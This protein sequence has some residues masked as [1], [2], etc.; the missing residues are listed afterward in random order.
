MRHVRIQ[1]A[2]L[3]AGFVALS[4][5][6][7]AAA[8]PVSEREKFE[9]EQTFRDRQQA[10]AEG[11]QALR[12]MDLALRRENERQSRWTNPLVLAII[13][14]AI[15]ALGNALVALLNGIQQRRLEC[16]RAEA[17]RT[18]ER[19]KAENLLKLERDK[20]KAQIQLDERKAESDRILE[21]I[22][23]GE[24][25]TAA[26]NLQFLLS[27]GLV[28][29]TGLGERLTAFLATRQP[30]TG[31]ALPAADGR[32]RFEGDAASAPE[33]AEMDASLRRFGDYLDRVGFSRPEREARIRF[34]NVKN[35]YYDVAANCV[36]VGPK[37]RSDHFVAY[38]EYMH[39]VLMTFP[40]A[41]SME[42]VPAI[43]IESGLAYYFPASFMETPLLGA[44]AA[45]AMN[46]SQPYIRTLKSAKGFADLNEDKW[47]NNGQIWGSLFWDI[48]EA[49]GQGATDSLLLSAWAS[50]K[51]PTAPSRSAGV[52]LKT[53]LASATGDPNAVDTIRD[54]IAKRGFPVPGAA[55]PREIW[56]EAYP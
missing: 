14:A 37:F 21:V 13:A 34:D 52:F 27:A 45:R 41:P 19:D 10:L 38:R 9:A 35:A 46:L 30:G 17:G 31:P 1:L 4:A 2:A 24:T 44:N 49:L 26:A 43:S 56:T 12:R 39:H 6:D 22:K 7:G 5:A 23:T 54:R 15:A 8:R 36:V 18:L 20:A 40:K 28:S 42:D 51:W 53:L 11:D 25:E 48:R 47:F 33:A 55:K 32:F 16:E 50:T 29:R 3:V